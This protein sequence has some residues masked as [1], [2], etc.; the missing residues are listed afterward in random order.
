[1]P[2]LVEAGWGGLVQAPRSITWTDITPYVDVT[3][4]VTITRG[5][6]D[7]LSETQPG[8]ASMTLDNA[9]GRFTPGNPTS[10]Y[11]PF[12]RRNAPI[13]VSVAAM[14]TRTGAAPYSV[15]MLG[16]S[17]DSPVD[18][19]RWPVRAG[20]A[21]LVNGRLRIPLTPGAGSAGFQSA[22][23]WR[24]P[25][26]SVCARLSTAATAN[27]SSAA[28]AHFVLDSVTNGTRIGFQH[29]PVAGTLRCVLFVGFVD[30]ASVD[31]PYSPIDHLWLRIRESAGTVYWETSGDGW[32][33]TVRRTLAT[34][35]WVASETLILSLTTSRT[36]GTG[37]YMEWDYLGAQIRPRF[38]GMV[39]EFPVQWDGLMS[40]V[41]VSATDLFK[42]LNRLPVL[43]S[44][45]AQEITTIDALTPFFSFLSAYYPLTE[46]SGVTAA[47]DVAGGGAGAL[48]LTQVSSGGTLEF[49]GDG[50]PETGESAPTFAPA[51][52][53]AGKYLVADLGAQ[54]AADS[55]VYLPHIE[56]W[57]KTTVNGRVICGLAEW[58]F[59]HQLTFLLNGSG[60]LAIEYTET[61]SPV[62]TITTSS[63][64]LSDGNW[65]HLV[66]DGSA[67]RV[68]VDGS[69][70]GSTLSVASMSG[71]RALH[72]GGYRG[73]RLWDGQIAHLAIHEANGP[74]GPT[75]AGNY[76]AGATGF[77][78]E[79]ADLRVQRLARYAGVDSVT[80]WGGTHDPVA[81]QGPAGSGVVA[82]LREVEAS[83]SGK[84]FAERDYYGLAYQSRDVRYNPDPMSEVFAIDYADLETGEVEL[85]DDDQKLCNQIQA[86][87]PGGA[88]QTVN[89]PSSIGAFGLYEQQLAILKTTDSRVLDA[90]FWLVSRYADPQPELREVPIEAYTMPNYLDILD[91]EI[92]SY[93]SVYNLPPQATASEMRV[94]VEG[95][96]ET[97]KHN[98]HLIQ[99]RT[100]ASSTDSVWVL[101]DSVYGVLDVTTRL[102]Y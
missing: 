51:A 90:A 9:D 27:G 91:A 88:T 13:R 72:V 83:E 33:W 89:A 47:G 79:T 6:S 50:P 48:A 81:T 54:A 41:Q 28:L 38:W 11:Y 96:T 71:L 3:S 21:G 100:S 78:G 101:E 52:A 24:L 39:N 68:Y 75:Y 92:S 20:G 49:G 23:E 29:N 53:S 62:S 66:Y 67:K 93:F 7:E 61:G 1:M 40:T 85:A 76:L 55:T 14:P 36:G 94:T 17:F 70:V 57:F 25:G 95:Y 58:Q 65:H 74:C 86:S 82:R 5:A 37:D 19:A 10:P 64:V 87:R 43:K 44:M 12:V 30:G 15:S 16:D 46:P 31:L 102:A 34:P 56:V 80:I 98:S 45:L 73:A 69:A 4:G 99:F 26:A 63:S 97:I 22:R 32:D 8:T 59:E 77:S 2:L 42:R 18:T 84:L 35:G 60:V